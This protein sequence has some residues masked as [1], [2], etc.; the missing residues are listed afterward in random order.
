MLEKVRKYIEYAKYISGFA[1]GVLDALSSFL[2][3]FP[4]WKPPDIN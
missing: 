3:A 2:Q 4:R 1:S